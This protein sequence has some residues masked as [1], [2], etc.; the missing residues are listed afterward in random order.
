MANQ[1]S[2]HHDSPTALD[3]SPSPVRAE[4]TVADVTQHR[5]G[6]LEIMKEMGINHCCGAH[7]SL[8]E[9]AAAAGVPLDA[10]L[11]ALNEPRRTPA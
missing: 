7:L 2:C 9:A 4:Q 5:A 1:C 8:R 10:L 6:A 11:A 3:A